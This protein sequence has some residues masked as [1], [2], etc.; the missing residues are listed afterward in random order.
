MQLAVE[1][2]APLRQRLGRALQVRAVRLLKLQAALRLH[3][4]AAPFCQ[5]L[6]C[7]PE[8]LL[9]LR[10]AGVFLVQPVL[11]LGNALLGA[12][13]PSRPHV[14][15]LR[16]LRALLAPGRELRAALGMLALQARARLFGVLELRFMARH[17]GVGPIER[18][19]RTVHGVARLIVRGASG[20]QAC[21]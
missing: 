10:Q 15:R 9:G 8:G 13:S 17:F 20:L 11:G 14:E 7:G 18:R 12:A 5:P 2:L 3:E 6:L 4:L 16:E 19:L 1:A 21:L